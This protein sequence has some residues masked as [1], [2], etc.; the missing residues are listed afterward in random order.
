VGTLAEDYADALLLFVST[1]DPVDLENEFM[2][3][4]HVRMRAQGTDRGATA[5]G[6]V[7]LTDTGRYRFNVGETVRPGWL[8]ETTTQPGFESAFGAAPA[9]DEGTCPA[10]GAGAEPRQGAQ[11]PPNTN[12]RPPPHMPSAFDAVNPEVRS[13]TNTPTQ[14]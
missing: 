8:P 1:V 9:E 10:P 2:L 4:H 11:A 7:H 14:E 3:A 12:F 5:G 13:S 6:P